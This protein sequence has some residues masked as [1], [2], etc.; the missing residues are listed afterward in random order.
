MIFWANSNGSYVGELKSLMQNIHITRLFATW[1]YGQLLQIYKRFGLNAP[2]FKVS[3]VLIITSN[4]MHIVLIVVKE[5][6]L[7]NF[8]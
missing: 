2:P 1:W 5:N 4:Q 3:K 6:L 8:M 7:C